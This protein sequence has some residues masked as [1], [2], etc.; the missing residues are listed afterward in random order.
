[1]PIYEYECLGCGHQFEYLVLSK[2][3]AA[4]CPSCGKKEL[5]QLI[6]QY[7]VSSAS[8]RQANLAAAKK[9]AASVHKEKAHEEHKAL[10]DHYDEH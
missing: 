6:S 3:P 9:K 1:M 7:A 5:K 10:H 8:T 4:E 2:S